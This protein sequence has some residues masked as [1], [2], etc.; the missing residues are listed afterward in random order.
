[1][2]KVRTAFVFLLAAGLSLPSFAYKVGGDATGGK[3]SPGPDK[4]LAA[5]CLPPSAS[6]ELNVNNVRALI[7]SGGDMWWDLVQNARYEIPKGSGRHSMYVGTLIIGGRDANTQ[8][9]R[10]A[11]QRYRSGGVDYYT[12]PLDVLGTAEIDAETCDLYDQLWAISRSQVEQ[13]RLCNCIDPDDPSCEG[14]QI[15][16]VI[17]KWPGNPVV[18]AD[19]QHL[20]MQSLLAP[21][22][23]AN[24]DGVYRYEDCDYPFYDLDNNVDCSSDRSAFLYG[25]FTLW[26]VFNDKGNIHG[27]SQGDPIGMEI[28][29]QGFGFNTNDEINNMT[30]YNYE[31]INRG[32]TTLSSCYFGVNIDSDIGGATDDYTGCDVERGFG[33]MYNGDAND[34]NFSGQLGYGSNPPAIGVDFFEGPYLDSNGVA[35]VF[36]PLDISNLTDTTRFSSAFAI[37]GLGFNDTIADN[38]RFGMRRYV[39]YNNPGTGPTRDPSTAPNYYNYLRGFWLDNTRMVYGGDGYPT[40]GNGSTN[41]IAD[42]MFPGDSD[43]F[44]WGTKGIDPGFDWREQNTGAAPNTPGDRRF[45]QSAGPFTLKPGLV[46]DITIGVVWARTSTGDPYESVIKVLS[47][48]QKAQSLFENCFRVLNGPDAPDLNVQE[49]D[50]ELVLFVTNKATSNNYLEEY[51]ELNYFIPE[52]ELKT[53]PV[54]KDTT[55]F[56]PAWS[57]LI[58]TNGDTL[59]V[60]N[61]TPI[62]GVAADT[63]I[64]L[65]DGNGNVVGTQ[66]GFNSNPSFAIQTT[67]NLGNKI[68]SIFNDRMIRFQGYMIY[69]LKDPTITA[70]DIFAEDGNTKARLVAQCDIRDFDGNGNP[71]GRIVNFEFDEELGFSVPKV[72]V[73]GSNEGII[74]SFNLKEDQFAIGD[75][76]LVNHKKYYYMALAYGYNNYRN[77]DPNDPLQ[78]DGQKEPFFLGRRNIKVTTAIPHIPVPELNGTVLNALY[79]SGPQI[80]R[81]EGRGNGGND[82]KLTQETEEKILNSPNYRADTL[83]YDYG[84]GP[85]NVKVIDPLKV[86]GG[87]YQLRVID[88]APGGDGTINPNAR[89]VLLEPGS[90]FGD[91]VAISEKDMST[92]YEQIMYDRRDIPGMDPFLGFSITL[93]QVTNPGPAYTVINGV[94]FDRREIENGF[95]SATTTNS[96]PGNNW[97]GFFG[98]QNTG[99]PANWV[100]SGSTDSEQDPQWN[101]NFIEL[102]V[103][104]STQLLWMD[105][106]ASF[107]RNI[108]F[109]GGGGIVP[110]MLTSSAS[111]YQDDDQNQL[112]AHQLASGAIVSIEGRVITAARMPNVLPSID[113]V[114]TTDRSKWTRCPVL[115]T[116]D[117][118]ALAYKHPSLTTAPEKLSLRHSPSVDKDGNF[119]TV[120]SG[121]STNPDAA[122]Y[123]SEWGYSWFPGYAIDVE[124]GQRLNLAFG[125]DS[126]LAGN[127]GRD[128]M[129]NPS[130]VDFTTLEGV[131]SNFGDFLA[132]GKH[133]LYVFG[134][135]P[136][137]QPFAS[138]PGYDAGETMKGYLLDNNGLP[139][140]VIPSSIQRNLWR[141]CAWAGIPYHAKGTN[142]LSSDIRLSLRVTKRYQT[143]LSGVH[144]VANPSNNN[145]PM[146]NFSMDKLTPTVGDNSAA[147]AALDLIQVVPNPYYAASNYETSQVDSRVKIVNL[148]DNCTVTI[149]ALNGTLVRRLEKGTSSITSLDW[150]MKNYANIPVASGLYLFHIKAPGIGERIVKWYGVMRP[151]DLDSF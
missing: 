52:F 101:S 98:D 2:N 31:L 45:M 110:Y 66:F 47:A 34:E 26:W 70:T 12:G 97:L 94:L 42:F 103:G 120:G 83:V 80:V 6:A 136:L 95:I 116:Q 72:K 137:E 139:R 61:S 24:G 107:E 126:Y 106:D 33:F 121:S 132:A 54:T 104:G 86:R 93:Y 114:L 85:V 123:I 102:V 130:V 108:S 133:Y 81:V 141:S 78:L 111:I 20:N 129:F 7:H 96:Q 127:N 140:S 32:T 65:F 134:A 113:V 125:E 41:I 4:K 89:W 55:V 29:A 3:S 43:P 105:P 90:P 145:Q 44:N 11:A 58:I 71:I 68:D 39:Y 53:T 60:F 118:S 25:D 37:N 40:P 84:M 122:N 63:T 67:I 92:P 14:Y 75:K 30:F 117:F 91:T 8:T 88:N 115:E 9:L 82:L 77:Y 21:F 62:N 135:N 23:D 112:P 109:F 36:N 142:W 69:Q 35:E 59:F 17:M 146:Y 99:N 150:D 138:M 49:L 143:G 10:V 38:E 27:E 131:I 13:F 73:N 46:N 18:Q 28:R 50:R 22:Y 124:T 128:M 56:S 19:G 15:P 76:R 79:G 148:P 48:D 16:E 144:T 149:Y 151:I 87:N 100:R 51:E 147:R 119:A 64:Q 57:R 74:H 5:D 1:M